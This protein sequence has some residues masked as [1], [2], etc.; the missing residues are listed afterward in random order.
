M[1]GASRLLD[2]LMQALQELD[3]GVSSS[4]AK[5]NPLTSINRGLS[6]A[7]ASRISDLNDVASIRRALAFVERLL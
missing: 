1:S 3:V 4:A 6:R 2:R 5:R 7:G